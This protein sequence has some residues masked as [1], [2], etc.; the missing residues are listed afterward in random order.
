M[1]FNSKKTLLTLTIFS[2]MALLPMSCDITDPFCNNSCG[3]DPISPAKDF[4]VKGFETENIQANGNEANSENF[5]PFDQVFK[6]ISLGEIEYLAIQDSK[7]SNSFPGM[8][9]ACSL[10]PAKSANQLI[11]IQIFNMENVNLGDGDSLA[12]GQD[13]T[14]LFGINYIHNQ[15]TRP[16]SEFLEEGLTIYFGDVY[17][18]QFLKDPTEEVELTFSIR[19]QLQGGQEF[20]LQNEILKI[21]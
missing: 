21:S 13:I 4:I 17:K 9:F 18:L 19:I 10:V 1:R 5:Y 2:G 8:A 14:P 20:N 6:T 7:K 12:I 16:I 3:C 15:G 11:N